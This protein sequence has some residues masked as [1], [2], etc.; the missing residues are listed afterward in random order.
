MYLYLLLTHGAVFHEVANLA[1][2]A[3]AAVIGSHFSL[4]ENF[5]VKEILLGQM[6]TN[7]NVSA[8]IMPPQY[9]HMVFKQQ[10]LT[11]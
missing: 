3:A 4:S 5:R 10:I 9:T 1:T 6:R 8:S 11:I 2:D 7:H